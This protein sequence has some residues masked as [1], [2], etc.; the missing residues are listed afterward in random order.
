MLVHPGRCRSQDDNNV[1]IV[2]RETAPPRSAAPPAATDDHPKP[3]RTETN[4]VLVPTTVTDSMDRLVTGLDTQNFEVYQDKTKEHLQAIW[5]QDAPISVGVI[6]DVSGSM[7]D[8]IMKSREAIRTFL[9]TANPQ[10]EFFLIAFSDRPRLVSDFSQKVEK[11]EG[12]LMFAQPHG[13]TALLDAIYLGLSTMKN[14]RYKRKALLI[15]SDGGYNHSRYTEGE[16]KSV[17]EEADVQIFSI[18]TFDMFART[19]E[20][21]YG[22]QL[23]SD[24]TSVTG[25][26]SFT[27]S[28]PKDLPDIANKIG[29]ALRNEYIL[30]YEPTVKPHDGKWHKIKVKLHPPKGL[31]PLHVSAK[32]GFYAASQ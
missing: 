20:E 12:S 2:P 14:A 24:V 26:E 31:P 4:L 23:L 30:A 27:V 19:P 10:D 6:F 5:S 9:E 18:G 25:G 29:I 8:K 13:T 28:D 22:P 21:R 1:H 11:L 17:V 16:V 32:Q 15:I 3:F 7:T